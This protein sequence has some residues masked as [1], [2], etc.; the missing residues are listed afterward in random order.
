VSFNPVKHVDPFGT[1]LLPGMLLLFHAPFLFGYAKPVPV[2]FRAL[3]SPR[4]ISEKCRVTSISIPFGA[5]S[6]RDRPI[7]Y[8]SMRSFAAL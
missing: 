8:S 3:R 7:S 1:V 2:S 5:D 4:A 6:A